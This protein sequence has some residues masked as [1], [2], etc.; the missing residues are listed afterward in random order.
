MDFLIDAENSGRPVRDFLKK[1]HISAA[2]CTRLKQ[3]DDGILLNGTRVT[4]RAVLHEGDVLSLALY[5]AEPNPKIRPLAVAVEVLLETP[6]FVAVNK[7]PYM[8]THP[9]H[10]HYDDTLANALV[11]HYRAAAYCFSPRFVNRLDRNTSGVVLVAKHAHA[12]AQLAGQI[13][14]C[15]MQKTYYAV[16]EGS[17]THQTVLKTGIRRQQ[18]SVI[19]REVCAK[20]EG[21]LAITEVLPLLIANGHTLVELRPRTG[22]THQLRVHMASLGTPI[23]GDD[24]YGRASPLIGRHALHAATLCFRASNGAL[25][26]VKAP[27]PPDML[28]LIAA[29][30][31]EEGT[32][33]VKTVIS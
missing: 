21:D 22:R 27:L 30:F 3:R 32:T 4:V 23:V 29:I 33:L 20:D 19:T 1:Q 28:S 24:L 2:L 31:G 10:G 12:A 18:E 6:E 14:A 8:P 9:S 11:Y 7:P 17:F 15:E 26:T 5:D 25:I 13:A 16:L